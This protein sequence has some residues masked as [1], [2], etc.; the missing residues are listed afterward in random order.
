MPITRRPNSTEFEGVSYFPRHR[1]IM[2]AVRIVPFLEVHYDVKRP[3]ATFYGGPEH[4]KA[5]LT[6]KNDHIYRKYAN[7]FF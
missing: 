3:F 5:N 4:T 1:P 2:Y 6:P 7:L